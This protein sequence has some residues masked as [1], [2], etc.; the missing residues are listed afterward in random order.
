MRTYD[1]Q[2]EQPSTTN[3]MRAMDRPQRHDRSRRSDA[4]LIRATLIFS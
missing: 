1:G 2:T 3:E 4:L